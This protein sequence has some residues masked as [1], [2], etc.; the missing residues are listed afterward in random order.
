M[1]RIVAL[2][3]MTLLRRRPDKLFGSGRGAGGAENIEFAQGALGLRLARRAASDIV[4]S[5]RNFP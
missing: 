4:I 3:S 5:K 2:K 1:S